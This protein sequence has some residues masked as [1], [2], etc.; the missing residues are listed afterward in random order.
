MKMNNLLKWA[1]C[2]LSILCLLTGLLW[3]Q[4]SKEKNEV[5]IEVQAKGKL[6]RV[7]HTLAFTEVSTGEVATVDKGIFLIGD[8]R[9]YK[10]PDISHLNLSKGDS[11]YV[12]NG[13]AYASM[14]SK[15]ELTAEIQEMEDL[16]R[17]MFGVFCM[18]LCLVMGGTVIWAICHQRR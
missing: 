6:D 3:K 4:K 14:P 2:S 7:E 11:V 12:V 8:P 18:L 16:A 17:K 10:V 13:K 1:V 15:S 9:F 5:K